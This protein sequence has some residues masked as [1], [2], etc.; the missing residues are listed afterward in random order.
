MG[1]LSQIL[2]GVVNGATGG[3]SLGGRGRVGGMS[4][5]VMALLPVVL[6]MLR[7]RSRA[8]VAIGAGAAPGGGGLGGAGVLGGVAGLGGLGALLNH[9]TQRGYGTQ[10]NS[11]VGTGANEPLPE[12]AIGEVFGDDQVAQIAQQAGVSE[13]EARS[14]LSE[15]LPE[16]VDHFTPD[17]A[18]PDADQLNSSV[19][20]YLRQLS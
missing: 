6:S 7:N 2:T 19:D 11:W 20:N 16:V 15:L 10:A 12:H 3:R 8:G 14:G 17:G 4:P 13:S 1:L 18:L 9:F 5:I